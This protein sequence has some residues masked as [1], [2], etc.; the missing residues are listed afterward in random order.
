MNRPDTRGVPPT[1]PRTPAR[2]RDIMRRRSTI[3]A[4]VAVLLVAILWLFPRRVAPPAETVPSSADRADSATA[5]DSVV[6]LDSVSQRLA[7]VELTTV[8]ESGTSGLIANGTITYDA[9][10][11]S[12]IAPLVEAR[13]VNVRADLGQAVR[14]GAVLA[15]LES[16]EIGQTRGDLERA[17][18]NVDVAQRNYTREKRLY[19]E[20][21]SPQK[22]LLDAEGTLKT[23]EADYNSALAKLRAVGASEGDGAFFGLSTPLSGAVVERNASPGQRVGPSTTLFTVADLRRVWISVDVYEG[24][25]AR[26]RTGA[27]AVVSPTAYPG[28]TFRGRV[29]YAGGIV[30]SASHTFKVRLEV[31]NAAGRLRP[32]MFAQVRIETPITGGAGAIAIPEA[33]VQDLDGQQV[34]FVAGGESGTYL[35]RTVTLGPRAGNGLVVI[36]TGLTA[37]EHV[38]TKGAF[39]LKSELTKARFGEE[40]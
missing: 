23:A 36:A 30:D 10:R 25:L 31:E 8:A 13:V 19:E 39:Q 32:G 18:V 1:P 14:A 40:G 24:D 17:R 34:V 9:N 27:V 22:E 12:I 4:V 3:I 28:E 6:R 20:Q 37:G 11:V 7:G 15:T 35:V 33:A 38:V 29:T 5:A 21:I 2:A 26:V 16:A